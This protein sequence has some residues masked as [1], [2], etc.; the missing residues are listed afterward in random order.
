MD[1]KDIRL[2]LQNP[3][4]QELAAAKSRIGWSL[5]LI[6]LI[7]YFGYLI[8]VSTNPAF[9]KESLSGGVT[10]VGIPIGVAVILSAIVL[11]GVYIRAA[12]KFD[13]MTAAIVKEFHQ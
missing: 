8:L 6:M 12:K 9:M 4:F 7:I 1:V 11:A 13:T 3:K 10:T 2:V 5:T